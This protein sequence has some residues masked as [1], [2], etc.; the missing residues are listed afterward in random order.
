MANIETLL[1][2][3]R[4]WAEVAAPATPSAGNVVTYAK[5]DGLM[6]SKDDAGVETLMSAGSAGSV[7]TDAIWDAP[8]DLA[9]GTGANTAAK[10]SGVAVGKVL[11]SG[12]V[13]TAVSWGYPLYH[14]ARCSN[15]AAQS[16]ANN[17]NNVV[18][19]YDTEEYDTDAIAGASGLFTVPAGMGG[20]WR[21]TAFGLWAGSALGLR[22]G[23]W[24]KNGTTE[25]GMRWRTAT[26]ADHGYDPML[27]SITV[28]LA[29]GD[30]AAWTVFQNTG[31]ALNYG[32][33]SP[34][35]AWI[36]AEFVGA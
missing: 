9:Q 13:G 4:Y 11:L 23:V 14:G 1:A 31:G 15:S 28:V 34:Y 19:T 20:K 35:C 24:Y 6:Y 25:I 7:A 36:E 29:A 10:L 27:Y 26:V 22:Y 33:T 12:G 32:D 30:T 5:A 21:L 3:T 17:T 16:I 18:T 8:G 2:D